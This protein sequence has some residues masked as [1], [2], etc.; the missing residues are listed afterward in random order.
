MI[1]LKGQWLMGVN[2]P[3]GIEQTLQVSLIS[4]VEHL[5]QWHGGV[6]EYLSLQMSSNC[7]H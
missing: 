1:E 2:L 7:R 5:Y 3:G 4:P 6:V